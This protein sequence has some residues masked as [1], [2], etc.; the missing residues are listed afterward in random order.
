METDG[1]SHKQ[2]SFV[3]IIMMLSAKT[4]SVFFLIN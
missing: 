3:T 4:I 2:T 1:D